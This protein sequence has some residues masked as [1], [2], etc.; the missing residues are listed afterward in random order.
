MEETKKKE[1]SSVEEQEVVEE[2]TD[3]NV[4]SEAEE[5]KE[6]DEVEIL[7]EQLDNQKEKYLRLSAEF[8]NYKN[9]VE[10]EKKDLIKYAHGEVIKDVLPII[11][12][13]DRALESLNSEESNENLLEGISHIKTSFDKFL[14]DNDVEVIEAEGEKFDPNLHHAVMKEETDEYDNNVVMDVLQKGYTLKSKVIRHAMVK[15][16]SNK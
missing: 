2:E 12:N 4:E 1:Q 11:D 8:K 5:A 3:K 13:F 15:V 14:E 10:R 9:R 16:A 7:K 6:K